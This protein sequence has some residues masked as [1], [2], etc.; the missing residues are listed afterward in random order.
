MGLLEG[1]AQPFAD[2]G[3][4][5][6]LFMRVELSSPYEWIDP[7]DLATPGG[8]PLSPAYRDRYGHL[9]PDQRPAG[10]IMVPGTVLKTPLEAE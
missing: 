9:E 8:R 6:A 7:L 2:L 3:Q 10:G 1:D 4:C 5:T